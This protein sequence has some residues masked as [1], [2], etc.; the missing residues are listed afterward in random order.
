MLKIN[1][2]GS[3]QMFQSELY[4]FYEGGNPYEVLLGD[5]QTDQKKNSHNI[6]RVK[7]EILTATEKVPSLNLQSRN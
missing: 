4:T 5:F 1:G 6:S 7:F 3:A 2:F